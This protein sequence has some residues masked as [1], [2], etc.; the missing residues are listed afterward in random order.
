MVLAP[1]TLS[2]L[3]PVP[4]VP[5]VVMPGQHRRRRAGEVVDDAA[6]ARLPDRRLRR[7]H[8]AAEMTQ[9]SAASSRGLSDVD[10]GTV[11]AGSGEVPRSHRR[12]TKAMAA[13]SSRKP[14]DHHSTAHV[15]VEDDARSIG[16]PASVIVQSSSS[17]AAGPAALAARRNAAR[18]ESATRPAAMHGRHRE[19]DDVRLGQSAAGPYGSDHDGDERPA[20]GDEDEE[21]DDFFDGG[22]DALSPSRNIRMVPSGTQNGQRNGRARPS[23]PSHR[24]GSV[25]D[26]EASALPGG[27]RGQPVSIDAS[28]FGARPAELPRDSVHPSPPGGED[29]VLANMLSAIAGRAR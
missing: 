25:A 8:S 9:R 4:G 11:V 13:R 21:G 26:D 15:V 6:L 22:I 14:R 28:T 3:P 16:A 12:V 7:R 23:P 17:A 1:G 24:S 20:S 10:L 18:D 27:Y 29:S 5:P 19:V 2:Q